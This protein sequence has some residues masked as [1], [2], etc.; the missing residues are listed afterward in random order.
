MKKRVCAYCRVS[1]G[2]DSQQGSQDNQIELATEKIMKNSEWIF[3]GIYAD[4]EATGTNANR[5]AFKKMMRDARKHKFDIILVK[6]ISR[7]ARNTVLVI[8]TLKKL[9]EL[10]ISVQFEKE[11]IDTGAPY[12]EMFLTIMSA[13]AQEESRNISER[14]KRGIRMRARNGY[15]SWTRLYGFI[16]KDGVEYII[17]EEEA[18]VVRRIFDEYEH[19]VSPTN[20]AM[21]LNEEGHLSPGGKNWNL[22]NIEN[23]L[24]NLK[25][26]GEILTNANYIVDH[27]THKLVKNK[28]EVERIHLVNHHNGIISKEQFQRVQKIHEMKRKAQYPFM[29]LL[30]CPCCGKYLI[31]KSIKKKSCWYCPEDNFSVEQENLEEAVL[32]AYE[33][34]KESNNEFLQKLKNQ[35]PIMKKV[36]YWWLSCTVDKITFRRNQSVLTVHWNNGSE[37]TIGL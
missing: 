37:T 36:D 24:K 17:V 15:V 12:S 21:Q 4:S 2:F 22:A 29:G 33:Q 25:Y 6:S 34:I 20:I 27:M 14:V 32:R 10:G 13:F 26:A 5:P 7:F 31:K 28:G 8:E 9:K 16:K 3:A 19:G 1:T 11:Q 30:T 35:Y 18:K 23:V